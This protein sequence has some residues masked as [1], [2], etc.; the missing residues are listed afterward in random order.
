MRH[1]KRQHKLGR[2]HLSCLQRLAT[3]QLQVANTD[4]SAGFR[5]SRHREFTCN[6]SSVPSSGS[7][8]PPANSTA[9]RSRRRTCIQ[10]HGAVKN[11]LPLCQLPCSSA[12]FAAPKRFCIAFAIAAVRDSNRNGLNSVTDKKHRSAATVLGR[13]AA[14]CGAGKEARGLRGVVHPDRQAFSCGRSRAREQ[15]W[16]Q[17]LQQIEP[18]KKSEESRDWAN[19]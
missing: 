8:A 16:K 5:R 17:R 9:P 11:Q 3:N 7:P 10:L 4:G 2:S 18:D 15:G 12:G 1:R 6:A 13:C 14:H 19:S